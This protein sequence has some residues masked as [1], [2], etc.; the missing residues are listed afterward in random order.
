[1]NLLTQGSAVI[2]GCGLFRYRL[3]RKVQ[4]RG[5]VFCFL[6][7][8]GSS[9]DEDTDDQTTKKWFGFTR[10]ND[11]SAYIAVNPFGYRSADVRALAAVAD[12]IGPD[13][14]RHLAAAIREADVLIPC[15]GRLKKIPERLRGEVAKLKQQVFAANKPIKVFGLTSDGDPKHPL[16]LGYKTELIP[17]IVNGP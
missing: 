5:P 14:A 16:M 9:A 12:P 8:N 13:N 3:D 7:I 4:P 17:W 10:A 15:W 1:M 2:S 11:G 6:G